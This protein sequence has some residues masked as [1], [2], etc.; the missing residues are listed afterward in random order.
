M[1]CVNKTC[2]KELDAEWKVCPFC[3]TPVPKNP[4][5]HSC[6]RE[7]DQAFKACPYCAAP[8]Q[9]AEPVRQTATERFD[10]ID[11]SRIREDAD[12]FQCQECNGHCLEENR[13]KHPDGL[14][15]PICKMCGDALIKP[16]WDSYNAKLAK[17][18]DKEEQKAQEEALKWAEEEARKLED[19]RLEKKRLVEEEEERIGVQKS[20]QKADIFFSNGCKS[21]DKK[22]VDFGRAVKG[23]RIAAETGDAFAQCRLGFCYSKGLGIARNAK[24]AS[25]WYLKAA[26]QG[27]VKAQFNM[28]IRYSTGKGV[29]KNQAEASRWYLK[30][31]ENGDARAQLNMGIRYGDGVGVIQDDEEAVRWYRRSAEQGHAQAQSNLGLCYLK[32]L[33][34]MRDAAE[35]KRWIQ[36]AAM[37]GDVNARIAL[38]DL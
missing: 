8:V 33:G 19:S 18:K 31:A 24:M 26:E 37:Q 6:G 38:Y 15:L 36:K 22:G 16:L 23:F 7:L 2:G 13:V 28:G 14:K 35:A 5:C 20:I 10:C 34:I 25:N 3:Q 21:C 12:Y 29:P 30:A 4:K 27:F 17:T 9:D 1:V 32:G 11:G